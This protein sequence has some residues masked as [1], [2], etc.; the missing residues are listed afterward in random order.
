M[1]VEQKAGPSPGTGWVGG[2]VR[3]NHSFLELS[4]KPWV[5]FTRHHLSPVVWVSGRKTE[6]LLF[7][8]SGVAFSATKGALRT[9]FACS[10]ILMVRFPVPGPISSTV[11]VGRMAACESGAWP[12]VSGA[13]AVPSRCSHRQPLPAAFSPGRDQEQAPPAVSVPPAT[14]VPFPRCPSPPG[15]SSRCADQ[16]LC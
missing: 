15:D 3:P 7:K 2:N 16:S 4:G 10:S 11:S 1:A 14:L 5:N 13:C 8:S 9:R 12:S 6:E